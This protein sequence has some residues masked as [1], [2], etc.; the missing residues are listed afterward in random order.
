MYHGE[1]FNA[2]THLV[3][4]ALACLG[5]IWL[6]VLAALDGELAKIVSAAIYGPA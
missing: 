1:R 3:G 4:A 2:W 6:L 5:A